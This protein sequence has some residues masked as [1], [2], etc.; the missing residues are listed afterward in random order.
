MTSDLPKTGK[1]AQRALEH[2]GIYT[3]QQLS[4]CRK[5]EVLSLHGMGPKAMGILEKAMEERGL[6]FKK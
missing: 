6:A 4:A 1:P 3:L 5:D 2:A